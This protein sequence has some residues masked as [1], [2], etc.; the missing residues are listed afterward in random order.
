MVN[1][2]AGAL[3]LF[4][5]P[6]FYVN[7]QR[8]VDLAARHRLP[9]VYAH[10]EA[11]E[12][13]GLMSYGAKRSAFISQRINSPSKNARFRCVEEFSPIRRRNCSI[14]TPEISKA[15]QVVISGA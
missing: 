9:T 15:H 11:V 7:Y 14:S 2:R 4:P 6:M 8:L 10:R 3:M 1:A 12:H 5:S 13:G